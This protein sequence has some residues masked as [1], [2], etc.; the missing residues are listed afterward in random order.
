MAVRV[1]LRI[2]VAG[3]QLE[4]VALVNSGFET[5]EPQLLVPDRLLTVNDISI[6]GLKGSVIEYGTP[7]GPISLYVAKRC[8]S[9]L[10]VEPDRRSKEVTVDLVISPTERE[11][12]ISDALGEEL[13]IVILSM[14]KGIWRFNDD[15]W[16]MSRSSYPP[17]YW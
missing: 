7:A 9:V 13:G 6:A 4:V 3:R 5:D 2:K 14:K 16:E 1:K 11:V 8:C 15:P 12:L 10:V 17:Q